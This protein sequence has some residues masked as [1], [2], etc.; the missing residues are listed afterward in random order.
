LTLSVA[1][2]WQAVI[3]VDGSASTPGT[4]VLSGVPFPATNGFGGPIAI[5]FSQGVTGLQLTAGFL[6]SVGSTT[7]E[8]FAADGTSL[9]TVSNTSLGYETFNLS[10]S[11]LRRIEGVL[12]TN[13]DPGGFGINGVGVEE[14]PAPGALAVLPGF[15][16]AWLSRR[17]ARK[18]RGS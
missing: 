5:L 14:I 9:G 13:T 18:M 2:D 11:D 3:Q 12:I 1:P 4:E 16:A 7:I 10:D 17:R 8:A 6:D 15:V